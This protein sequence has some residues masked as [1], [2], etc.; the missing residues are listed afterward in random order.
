MSVN[1]F[2]TR[3]V[4]TK[5]LRVIHMDADRTRYLRK[6]EVERLAEHLKNLLRAADARSLL[7]LSQSQLSRLIDSGELK[8]ISG[9]HV[10]R[11]P[12]NVFLKSDVE[13]LRRERQSF[14]QQRVRMGGSAR[15]GKR[16]GPQ[17]RP[18]ME[19]IAPR[20]NVWL[21]RAKTKRVR[22]SGAS[23]H[24]RLVHEGYKVGIASVYVY[25]RSCLI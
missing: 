17:S 15:F 24:R 9:P 3:F 14:K 12:V 7:E 6:T 16:C 19:A 13:A 20:I 10:D 4:A 8:P 11:S 21:A 25:L 23:I 22:P 5:R 1:R 2:S 18:V